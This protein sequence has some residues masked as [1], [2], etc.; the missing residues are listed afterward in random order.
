MEDRFDTGIVEEAIEETPY[1]EFPAR[2]FFGEWCEINDS[3]LPVFVKREAWEQK[4][5]ILKKTADESGDDL[6]LLYLPNDLHLWE[7]IDVIEAVDN[8][9]FAR[10][11]ELREKGKNKIKE[12][13][14]T[15]K[16]AGVYINENLK[17]LEEGKDIAEDLSKKF[18]NYGLSLELRVKQEGLP[19]SGVTLDEN[20]RR[21]LDKWLLG[22]TAYKRRMERLGDNPKQEDIDSERKRHFKGYFK[23]LSMKGSK[24]EGDRPWKQ[25]KGPIQKIREATEKG[26]VRK[27]EETR[28]GLG[29]S[30]FRRGVEKLL[31]E[32]TPTSK[33][34]WEFGFGP[35]EEYMNLY[36]LLRVDVMKRQLKETRE[37]GDVNMISQKELEIAKKIYSAIISYPYKRGANKPSEMVKERFLN[38]VGSSLLGG[39]LL[40]EVGIKYLHAETPGH[41]ATVLITSDGKKYW[42]DFTPPGSPCSYQEITKYTLEEGVDL[43]GVDVTNVPKDRFTIE[44]TPFPHVV[45]YEVKLYPP[46][47]GL[48]LLILHNTGVALE[49][50][51]RMSE[52]L[53]AYR[54]AIN[55]DPKLPHPHH[56]LGD[57][58]SD[59]GRKEEA[60]EAYREAISI[61]PN[62]VY[63]HHGLGD[64][65]SDLGRKEEAIEAY[66]QAISIDSKYATPYYGLGN[67]LTDLGRYKEA[68]EAYGNF[69]LFWEGDKSWIDRALMI[70]NTLEKL[71]N[72]EN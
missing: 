72:K 42:Q 38:C 60:I 4:E 22:E 1:T 58:L 64:A 17:I 59:L 66:R 41:S 29:G 67:V 37:K 51:G 3:I 5:E 26:I 45:K 14:S 40:D 61:D 24:G 28:R 21:K 50:L 30:I 8:E 53:E 43:S 31:T 63:P 48:Q 70:M 13:G 23:A 7:M 46:E 20:D 55:L 35:Q 49:K 25:S 6:H 34:L 54:Q 10:K 56:G 27:V 16:K 15:F 12:L 36:N 39:A 69:V 65:L 47:I 68:M 52:A 11:P 33:I 32:M 18:F 57:A 9:T 19:V 44:L 71:V 62:F 2:A